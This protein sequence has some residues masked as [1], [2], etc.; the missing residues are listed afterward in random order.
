MSLEKC[1]IRPGDTFKR[2]GTAKGVM[3]RKVLVL[4][5]ILSILVSAAVLAGCGSGGSSAQTPEQV[6]E[7][8]W[9]ALK[10]RN[11][12]SSWNMLTVEAQKFMQSKSEW[13][14]SLKK[15]FPEDKDMATVKAGKATIN[16]NK[17]TVTTT[18]TINGQTTTDSEQLI[19]ENGVWKMDMR[20]Q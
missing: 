19:K 11:T 7:A 20:P 15:A 1:R 5:C 12:D 10:N 4:A 6:T 2:V 3:V 17:A 14:A 16:G 13:E 8:F 9:A 18:T